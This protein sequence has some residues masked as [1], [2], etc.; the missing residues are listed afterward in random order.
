MMKTNKLA[1]IISASF[2]MERLDALELLPEGSVGAG[3]Y[4]GYKV[5]HVEKFDGTLADDLIRPGN[6]FGKWSPSFSQRDRRHTAATSVSFTGDPYSTGHA[7]ANDGVPIAG[8]SDLLA[9]TGGALRLKGRT[10]TASERALIGVRSNAS[11]PAFTYRPVVQGHVHGL[12]HSAAAGARIVEWRWRMNVPAGINISVPG[13]NAGVSYWAL[14]VRGGAE[15]VAGREDDYFE[16][17]NSASGSA[18]YETGGDWTPQ[19]YSSLLNGSWQITRATFTDVSVK[20]ETYA[21][22]GLTL[23]GTTTD[24]YDSGKLSALWY[25]MFGSIISGSARGN[26]FDESKWIAGS[27]VTTD[28][29]SYRV[30]IPSASAAVA[31]AVGN[32]VLEIDYGSVG[33]MAL[34]SQV[35]I[36]GAAVTNERI[37]FH[38]ATDVNAPGR[39]DE[40]TSPLDV[41][42]AYPVGTTYTSGTRT[43][44]F[45]NTFS[46]QAGVV[47]GA[48][49]PERTDI[50]FAKPYKFA[51][52]V[53][54]KLVR[55]WDNGNCPHGV[56]SGLTLVSGPVWLS[57]NPVTRVLSGNCPSGF[58]GASLVFRCT[59]GANIYTEAVYHLGMGVV[60]NDSLFGQSGVLLTDHL[61]D[62][63]QAWLPFPLNPPT[64]PSFLDGAGGVYNTDT[65]GG[66]YINAYVPSTANYAVEADFQCLT[67]IA[68]TPGISARAS[69][70]SNDLYFF[71]YSRAAGGWQ[72]F[73]TINGVNTQIGSTSAA[74]FTAGQVKAI[75]FEI[76]GSS[77]I[78]KVDGVVLVSGT[79]TGITATGRAGLRTSGTPQTATTGVHIKNFKVYPL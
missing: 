61:S 50:G 3:V 49:Y 52:Y 22:D 53:R 44:A 63:G 38:H 21:D 26:V 9:M 11:G 32:A 69:T 6:P 24:N 59:N 37:K 29:S 40:Y 30:W 45:S 54:P 60:A 27:E 65:V 75:R 79:D 39:V 71:R 66:I 10:A 36:W 70:T 72:I 35:S 8:F 16:Y 1:A 28:I 78:G 41:A 43:L 67:E 55:N 13:A 18:I 4:A 14:M 77:L 31:P 76:N 20:L 46:V 19:G 15:A 51:V 34:P 5:A 23:L 58:T 48:V 7:D 25:F 12:A 42:D 74:T 73:K 57:Y 62:S 64:L 47:H 68:D 56:H 2:G 33:A 17:T